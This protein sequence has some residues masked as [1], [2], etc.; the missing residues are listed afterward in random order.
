MQPAQKELHSEENFQHHAKIQPPY[1]PGQIK[2]TPVCQM[3]YKQYCKRKDYLTLIQVTN[4]QQK[5][6][7]F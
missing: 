1:F 7:G 5:I 6:T 3:S 4:R 2:R